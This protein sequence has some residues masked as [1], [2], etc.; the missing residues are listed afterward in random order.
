MD[1]GMA[2]W[3]KLSVVIFFGG[4]FVAMII[5]ALW[6]RDAITSAQIEPPLIAAPDVPVKRRPE[7]PGGMDIPNRDKMVF[8]LLDTA[9]DASSG[10]VDGDGAL[11]EQLAQAG[12]TPVAPVVSVVSPSAPAVEVAVSPSVATP[13]ATV[14]PAAAPVVAQQPAQEV[15]P[16]VDAPKAEPK[17]EPKVAEAPKPEAKP[18]AKPAQTGGAWAVQLGAVGSE[19][20]A[21][22]AAADFKKK[23]PALSGLNQR[24]GFTGK[25]YR[26][27]F[28]GL[29]DRAEAKAVCDKLGAK[30]PCLPVQ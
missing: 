8:D 26:V 20:D 13:V 16:V 30:Q 24:I 12:L 21:N 5:Y 28:V 18:A 10:T 11:A 7:E 4:G 25:V 17:P 2:K 3:L 1:S 14:T 6:M 22:K 19:A 27:Q 9:S 15:K 23:Y 29:R